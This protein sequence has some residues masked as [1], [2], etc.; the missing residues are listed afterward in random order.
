MLKME[1]LKN[2]QSCMSRAKPEEMTFVLLAR[3]PAAPDAIRHWVHERIRLG[4]NQPT[5]PQIQ[6]A[7]GCAKTMEKQFEEGIRK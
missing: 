4:K 2:P 3:D 6:E 7:L 1:E 5:D